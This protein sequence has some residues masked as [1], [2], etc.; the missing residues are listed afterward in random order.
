[1]EKA[2]S[3]LTAW[4]DAAASDTPAAAGTVAQ[5]DFDAPKAAGGGPGQATKTGLEALSNKQLRERARQGG[6][7]AEQLERAADSDDMKT[8]LIA[9]VRALET[10]QDA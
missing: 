7:T 6:L 5:T 10:G 2:G 3:L 9:L 4:L 1:M 8:V